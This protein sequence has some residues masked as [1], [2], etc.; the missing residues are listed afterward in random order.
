MSLQCLVDNL[1]CQDEFLEGKKR[2]MKRSSDGEMK[3]IDEAHGKEM[4]DSDDARQWFRG[5]RKTG[6]RKSDRWS[7]GRWR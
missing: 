5:G 1:R 4:Y 3:H 7:D 2:R 6:T